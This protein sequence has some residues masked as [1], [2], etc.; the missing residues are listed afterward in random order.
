MGWTG[1]VIQLR[2]LIEDSVAY[3]AGLGIEPHRD[4]ERVKRI[5][6]D[7]D[8]SRCSLTFTFGKDGKPYFIAGPNDTTVKCQRILDSLH[9][10]LGPDGFHYLIPVAG[11]EGS[12]SEQF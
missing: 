1:V 3:A 8:S 10:R 11:P 4:Y 5:F 12:L 9:D 7:I 2:K 6:T